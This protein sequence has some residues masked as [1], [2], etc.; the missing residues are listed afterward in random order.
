MRRILTAIVFLLAVPVFAADTRHQSYVS[1]D[2][3]GTVIVQG[4]DS[5]EIDARVNMP[6][7]PGDQVAT[8]RRG[9]AELRLSDGNVVALD[10]A[11]AVRF[12]SILD[13]YEG[14]ASQTVAEVRYGKVM[15]FRRDD[16]HEAMRLD[17]DNASYVASASSLFSIESEAHGEDHVTVYDGTIEVRTPTRRTRMRAG[18]T[19][20]VDDRGVFGLASQSRSSA[21]DF[22]RW[23]MRRVEKYENGNSKYL[24]RSM[25]YYDDELG[26]YGNWVYAGSYGGWVW[27]PT[28]AVGWRPYYNGQWTYSRYGC[29]TWV[30]YEPWGWLPYHYGRWTYDPMYGWVWLPGTGYAPAWVY[31]M[32]GPNYIGWAPAGWYDCHRGYYDWA[33]RPYS[34]YGAEFG[35]GFYGRVRLHDVDLRPWTFVDSNTIVS[36]RV[37]R[38]AL[39]TDA[40]RERLS[41]GGAGGYAT[42]SNT[43]ARFTRE[44]LRDPA[45]AVDQIIRRGGPSGGGAATGGS[46]ARTGGVTDMT[47]FFRRDADVNGSIRER[48]VRGH[49]G[50]GGSRMP[51]NNSPAGGS[52]SVSTIGGG[53][54]APIGGGNVAPI[55]GGNVAPIGGGSVAPIG[56]GNVAPIGG[57]SVAPTGRGEG[58][59]D[60]SGRVHRGGDWR[61]GSTDPG[62]RVDRGETDRG[63][64]TVTRPRDGESGGST[65]TPRP[66]R[67]GSWR[68]R[69]VR[70]EKPQGGETTPDATPAPAPPSRGDDSWRGRA[71]RGGSSRDSGSESSGSADRSSSGSGSDVPRRVIDRI[72]GARVRPSEPDSGRSSG[73]ERSSGGSRGGDSGRSVERS[74]PPP[75]RDSGGNH[76]APE[77]QDGGRV[78]RD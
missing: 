28:V 74:S 9:R 49:P 31:W 36:N 56:G 25:A 22:E 3:G 45:N 69:V 24:D 47:P 58:S 43:P 72:G 40:V 10:R 32:Y 33:Y 35:V 26:D 71:V 27:R 17:T 77:K 62:T 6:V 54:I 68:E 57:G 19:A 23:F 13:A 29:L 61:G 14:E 75:Q 46:I 53:N 15:V 48:I 55:G 34:R 67:D 64:G 12:R 5:R 2:D 7:F 21:D 18:E 50:E 44:Q 78:K 20:G 30:S 38:A 52:G 37:D 4:D 41:R 76:A 60:T 16:S 42:V 11:T 70:P 66:S 39:T 59:A 1:Y 63:T 8:N 65:E 73:G 51:G